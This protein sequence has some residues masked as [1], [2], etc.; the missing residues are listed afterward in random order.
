MQNLFIGV[1]T[2]KE[3]RMPLD[4]AYVPIQ[5][6]AAEKKT[7]KGYLR[8]DSGENISEYNQN[9]SELTGLYYIWKNVNAKYKGLVHYRRYFK[10][11]T[12][13]FLQ[14]D[15]FKKV[16]TSQEML[17]LLA[18]SDII[19][20]QKRDY[21]IESNYQH[22]CHAHIPDGLDLTKRIIEDKYPEYALS[23]NQVLSKRSAHMFN[24]FI[25]KENVFNNYCE[26][27]FSVLFLLQE[28]IDIS[29]YTGQESR[30]F[31][32]ISELLLD[33]WLEKNGLAYTERPVLYIEKQHILK[34]GFN[35]IKRKVFGRSDA[36]IKSNVE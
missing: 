7:I 22:Y 15:R 26:W 17:N 21:I 13:H 19:L 35:M 5:V 4:E 24:M 11:S 32:Y 14:R 34:K 10:S 1:A 9:F 18:D 31:G 36:H 6:G 33:V 16:M 3:Y 29:N 30:I 20:P 8:D 2:H 23:L 27:L 12:H 28:K 25:M